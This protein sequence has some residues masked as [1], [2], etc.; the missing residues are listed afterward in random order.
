[1][2]LQH[3]EPLSCKRTSST[4]TKR[5]RASTTASSSLVNG[6]LRLSVDGVQRCSSQLPADGCWPRV[7]AYA[8]ER[9]S[10]TATDHIIQPFTSEACNWLSCCIKLGECGALWGERER[11]VSCIYRQHGSYVYTACYMHNAKQDVYTHLCIG[12]PGRAPSPISLRGFVISFLSLLG[13][14]CRTSGSL[15]LSLVLV[16]A[17][18]CFPFLAMVSELFWKYSECA[19][20]LQAAKL[21]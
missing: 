12:S 20:S 6:V 9:S 18:A 17:V 4:H 1:M 21:L 3:H 14:F 15:A 19:C 16:C 10:S 2:R 7:W 5:H 13:C 8:H 11:V